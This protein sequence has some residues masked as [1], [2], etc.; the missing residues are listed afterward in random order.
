MAQVAY[1]SQCGENVWVTPDGRCPKG[2]GPESLSNY[3]EAPEDPAQPVV[4]QPGTGLPQTPEPGDVISPAG[5]AYAGGQPPQ[6]KSKTGLIIGIVVA[7]LLLCGIGAGV[8]TCVA[9]NA[10]EDAV[11]EAV[12]VIEEET[13][14]ETDEAP[15][16]DAEGDTETDA[17]SED[18]LADA[19]RMISH[20]YPDFTLVDYAVADENGDTVSYH[21][22]AQSNSAD[23]F[24][25]TFFADRTPG[26]GSAD[27]DPT[28]QYY[29]AEADA[30]W[31]HPQTVES[32]LAQL[33]GPDAM[34]DF[35]VDAIMVP[36]GEAH[37]DLNVTAY[38]MDSNVMISLAGITDDDLEAWYDDFVSF[39]SVWEMGDDGSWSETSFTEL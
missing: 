34:S 25:I 26:A 5:A 20:F 11:D 18:I 4:T 27:L 33:A 9:L 22:L 17:D 38:M 35:L 3:F 6:K 14:G 12:S 24:Y 39:E 15:L 21:L 28:I 13:T 37:S 36:F 32:G 23:G 29:D 19:E 16:G 10:A 7:L 31:D 2:H 1:C 8:A 30:F